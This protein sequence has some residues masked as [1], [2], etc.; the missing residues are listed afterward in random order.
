MNIWHTSGSGYVWDIPL[1]P[2]LNRENLQD[3]LFCSK[4]I[5]IEKE[6]MHS[7]GN[8]CA[9]VHH[10]MVFCGGFFIFNDSYIKYEKSFENCNIFSYGNTMDIVYFSTLNLK[11]CIFCPG[12]L[13]YSLTTW[14]TYV[15]YIFQKHMLKL[16]F[17]SL[18]HRRDTFCG[19]QDSN[20]G[21]GLTGMYMHVLK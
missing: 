19:R 5:D 9:L 2:F 4:T 17:F 21:G 7:S 8:V 14:K 11:N 18:W 20:V 13:Y 6:R 1:S 16:K 10:Q 15:F 3:K 12:F